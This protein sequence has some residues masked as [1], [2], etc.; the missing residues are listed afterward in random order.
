MTMT[1]Q[2][3]GTSV[4]ESIVVNAPAERAFHFDYT[5]QLKLIDFPAS[6]GGDQSYPARF[7]MAADFCLLLP[8]SRSFS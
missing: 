4:R 6:P 8:S 5:A 3:A 7:A 1:T 2:Q